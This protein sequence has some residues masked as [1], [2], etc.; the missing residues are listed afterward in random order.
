MIKSDAFQSL[1][2]GAFMKMMKTLFHV[3][4]E[5]YSQLTSCTAVKFYR[6]TPERPFYTDFFGALYVFLE[7]IVCI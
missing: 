6:G 2:I 1:A 3:D 5:S 4:I 7:I